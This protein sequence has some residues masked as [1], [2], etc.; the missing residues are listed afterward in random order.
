MT[1]H[2]TDYPVWVV[3]VEDWDGEQYVE[4]FVGPFLSEDAGEQWAMR[5]AGPL[6]SVF[7]LLAPTEFQPSHSDRSEGRSDG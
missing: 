6:Y 7:D 2:R 4:K 5:S 1:E 3:C